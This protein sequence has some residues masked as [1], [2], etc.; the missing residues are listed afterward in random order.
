[1]LRKQKKLK[2]L[3]EFLSVHVS[4]IFC[5]LLE[6]VMAYASLLYTSNSTP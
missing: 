4:Y 5:K 1:M 6:N 2:Y 3:G